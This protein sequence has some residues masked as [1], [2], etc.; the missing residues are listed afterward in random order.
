MSPEVASR[1]PHGTPADAWALGCAAYAML[2]GRP[3]FQASAVPATL[4]RVMLARFE[5]PP[6]L[7][8][9]ARDHPAPAAAARPRQAA[10]P[11]RRAGTPVPGRRRRRDD[12][13]ADGRS[14][15][16]AG[17][18]G[19][20]GQRERHHDG[21]G[22][23]R[24]RREGGAGARGGRRRQ[25]GGRRRSERG[26]PFGRARGCCSTTSNGRLS[27]ATRE[28]CRR[29]QR[30]PHND[31]AGGRRSSAARSGPVSGRPLPGS[32]R[33]PYQRARRP[34]VRWAAMS[35]GKVAAR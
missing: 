7:S 11:A 29:R 20:A 25:G 34:T 5:L 14:A 13:R 15:T 3:P 2:V 1:G 26:C 6:T 24:R 16:S 21:A 9:A 23:R 4:A 32:P 8:P 19:V 22:G 27:A 12:G 31:G 33:D 35:P 28:W 10:R 18:R 17:R 30:W